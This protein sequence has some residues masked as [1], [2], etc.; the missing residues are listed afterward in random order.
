MGVYEDLGVKPIINLCG[1]ATRLGGALMEQQVVD[2][3]VQAAQES[4]PMDQLQAA[5]SRILA[6]VTGAEAGYVTA[7]AAS[8]LTLGTAACMTGLDVAR[9]D[10]LP[11]TTDMPNE[12]IIARE[13][14]NGY[15]HAIR[16]AGAKLVEVGMNE[17]FAGAGVRCTEAWEF[18]AAITGRTAAI[19][20]FYRPGSNPPLEEVISVGKKH[21]IPVLV[22]AAVEVPPVENLGKFISM[23]ADLV[24]FSGGK[25]IRGPN[26]TGI[27]CGRR[28]LI[29]AVALQHLDLDEHFGIWEPP[30]T[31]IRKEEI[32]GL[33]RHGIG[34]GFKVAK[35]EIVGLLTALRLFTREKCLEDARRFQAL[36][37]PIASHLRGIPHIEVETLHAD[38]RFPMLKVKLDERALGLNAFEVSRRLKNGDPSVH[39]FEMQLS[40]GILLISPLNLNEQRANIAAQC[41]RAVFAGREEGKP[42]Y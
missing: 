28:D 15:D 20:Y 35:E 21:N 42:M 22:D 36:L 30:P 19:A 4:V 10:R 3:M 39:V 41:L 23:G 31:L 37:E 9:M 5:A 13:H 6:E 16:A 14:R 27:L 12:V 33:P 2:A 29:A 34:R 38:E 24:C 17:V 7:G 18:E 8:S 32:Q 40:E 1:P 11:D 26:S 25:F